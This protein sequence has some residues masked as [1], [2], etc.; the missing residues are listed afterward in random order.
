MAAAHARRSI[1]SRSRGNAESGGLLS[2]I[3]SVVKGV[4]IALIVTIILVAAFAL[5]IRWLSPGATVVS[6]VN[7]ALKLIS[8]AA[9]VWFV[10]RKNADGALLKGIFI[11]LVY[12]LLGIVAISLLS[13]VPIAFNSYLADLGMGIAGGGLCGMILPGI[14]KK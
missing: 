2:F 7:Q 11:G 14:G 6:V 4:I 9:G 12:M 8:I 10:T 3:G 13:S 1:K 5:I